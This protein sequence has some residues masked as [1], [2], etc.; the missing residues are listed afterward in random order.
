MSHPQPVWEL[1]LSSITLSPRFCVEQGRQSCICP[2]PGY[3][4]MLT[5]LRDDGTAKLRPIDDFS[6]SGCNAAVGVSE[7]LSYES[8]DKFL[9]LLRECR[10]FLGEDLALWKADIDSAYRRRAL[11]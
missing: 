2:W 8:T 6:R 5:G 11:S 7:E 4:H 9:A 1:D 10:E 3:G